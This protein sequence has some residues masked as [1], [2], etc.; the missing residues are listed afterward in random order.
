MTY[1]Y[2]K[3]KSVSLPDKEKL[4]NVVV[5]SLAFSMNANAANS[6]IKHWPCP[7]YVVI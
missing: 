7:K 1:I 4:L 2:L 6:Q 5:F 3:T